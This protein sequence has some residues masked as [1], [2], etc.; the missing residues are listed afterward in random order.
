MA[1][2]LEKEGQSYVMEKITEK[3][4]AYWNDTN[5]VHQDTSQK[6]Y[7]HFHS[8]VADLYNTDPKFRKL[9]GKPEDAAGLHCISG[10]PLEQK[11]LKRCW[12][13]LSHEE[14]VKLRFQLY[15]TRHED[16]IKLQNLKR[17]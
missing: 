5:R 15:G 14:K 3:L 4:V 6:F 1:V 11:M 12:Q 2:R 16:V 10:N 17:N 9:L 7:F 8:I 13:N